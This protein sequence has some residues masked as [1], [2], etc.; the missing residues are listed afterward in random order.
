MANGKN[1]AV[2]HTSAK[3]GV[4][5]PA[6]IYFNFN[7]A[8]QRVLEEVA[9]CKSYFALTLIRQNRDFQA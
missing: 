3:F 4:L 2:F 8:E 6:T 1:C 9:G 7:L 5:I